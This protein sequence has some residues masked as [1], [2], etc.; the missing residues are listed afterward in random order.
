[1]ATKSIFDI[2][3]PTQQVSMTQQNPGAAS[4]EAI[5]AAQAQLVAAQQ[6][7]ANP[8]DA[9][10]PLWQTD[11]KSAP[12]VDPLS[13]PLFKTD[14][15]AIAAAASKMDFVS[16]IPPEVMANAMSGK[17][18]AAFMQ[19]LNI[20]GQRATATSAQLN[21]AT[22]EQSHVRNNQRIEQVL[23]ARIKQAQLDQIQPENPALQHA[24]SQPLLQLVRAQVQMKNP[25]MSAVE[26]NNRAEQVLVEY[27]SQLVAPQQAAATQ[28][29]GGGETNWETWAGVG[30]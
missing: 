21:A 4:A 13:T 5:A 1:M 18:P 7:P 24:A 16:G 29:A 19:V 8:L 20:V 2:F 23:P 30:Q 22:I 3:R 17:D 27:A 26:I 9:L 15:A 28:A 11:P 6:P 25:G 12:A 14:P 10:T